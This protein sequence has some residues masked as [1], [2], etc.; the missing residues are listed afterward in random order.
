M[1]AAALIVDDFIALALRGDSR[2]AVRLALGLLDDGTPEELVIRDLLAAAQQ[3]VGARWQANELSIADEHLV[4]CASESA[5]HALAAVADQRPGRGL[6][7]VAC[8]DGD[9]HAIAAQ[10]FAE[11]LRSRDVNVA[12]LGASTPADHVARLLERCRPDALAI[13][14]SLPI[15]YGG[16]VELTDAAHALGVPVLAG[17]RAFELGA[18]VARGLGADG[19]ASGVD[20]AETVVDRWRSAPPTIDEA[21]VRSTAGALQLTAQAADVAR[22]AF[23][24][25]IDHFPAMGRYD[26]RQLAR[27]HEDLVFIVQFVGS[28]LLVE[29][30]EILLDLL[31]WLTH[32]LDARCVPVAALVGGVTALEPHLASI[33]DDAGRLARLALSRLEAAGLPVA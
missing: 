6:V 13:S 3:D 15:F 28:A 18:D 1:T 16:V 23:H 10:L 17:G 19:W 26:A 14:C 33:S 27:T 9:W 11:Q 25:L 29:R 2:G 12:F 20:D 5:L 7:V 21:P 31:D 32:V 4:T 24:D 30:D 8:A 22:L